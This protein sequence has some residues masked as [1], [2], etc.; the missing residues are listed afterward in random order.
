MK[1]LRIVVADDD[2]N[3]RDLVTDILEEAGYTVEAHSDGL[4][5]LAAVRAN[6]PAVALFDVAMPVMTGDEAL[7]EIQHAGLSVPVVIM[8]AGTQPRRFL[9]LGAAAVLPKPFDIA[10][11]L[12]VIA[13]VR[14]PPVYVQEHVL[15]G[16]EERRLYASG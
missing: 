11:L 6:L 9:Q 12:T 14:A 7:Q 8:T 13:Q 10:E 2:C 1:P 4:S 5:A 3:I 16:I 15:G